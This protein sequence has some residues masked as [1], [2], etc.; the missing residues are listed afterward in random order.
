MTMIKKM[1]SVLLEFLFLFFLGIILVLV[2]TGGFSFVVGSLTVKAHGFK[3]PVL[4]LVSILIIRRFLFGSFFQG[5][6]WLR[7][8]RRI[9]ATLQS[10]SD[11]LA[12]QFVESARFRRSVTLAVFMLL[13]SVVLAIVFNPLQHGLNATYYNNI[14]GSGSPILTVR[15][16]VINLWRMLSVFPKITENYS[17]QWRGVIFIP[18]SGEYQFATRSDDGSKLALDDQLVVDN[19]GFH[20]SQE[21]TGCMHLEPGFHALKIFYWQGQGAADFRAYWT[22]PG[23]RRAEL[24]NA[25]LFPEEPA[26][27]A[28]FVG[29]WLET[30]VTVAGWLCVVGLGSGVLIGFSSHRMLVPFFRTSSVGRAY[31]TCRAWIFKAQVPKQAFPARPEKSVGVVLLAFAGYA[32]LSLAWTYPLIMNFS[33]KMV[34]IGGDRYIGLWNMWWMKKALL[35]LHVNPMYTDYLFYPQGINLAFHDYSIFN[36]LVSVPLQAFFSLPEIYNLLFL[37]TY[38]LGGLGCF[39]LVS[40]LTGDRYAAFLSGLVFAFWGGRAYYSDHLSFATIQWFPYCALYLIKTLRERSYRNP[41]RAA[42]FLAMNGLSCGYY[43]IYMALFTALFLLYSAW[44]ERKT[45]FTAACLT[46]FGLAGVL[47]GLLIFPSVYPM[48]KDVVSGESYMI[49]ALLPL[50]SASPNTL[51]LPSIN[52][53]LIGTYMRYLYLKAGLP[54]QWGLTGSAFI[55]YTVLGLCLY[56]GFKLRHLKQRFW[57]IAAVS[58]LLLAMGPHLLLFSK[59]YPSIPLPYVL[60]RYIPVLKIVRVPV[61]FMVMAMFCGSVLVGYACWDIFRRMRVKKIVFFLLAVAILFEFFRFLGIAP[62]ETTPAFYKQ[63]G[64][65]KEEYAILELTKLMNWEHSAARS[66]LFQTTHG[67]KLFHGHVSRVSL[68]TYHQAYALYTVFNDLL[69]CPP[70]K[71]VSAAGQNL[72]WGGDKKAITAMLSFYNVRYVALYYDY[73]YGNYEENRN[74]LQRLFGKPVSEEHGICLFKV[75][76]TPL[77]ENLVFP[78]F[79]IS[80]LEFRADGSILRKTARSADFKLLNVAQAQKVQIRFQG[81]SSFLPKEE[82]VQI[83]VNETLA[84]T[85]TIGD[86]TDVTIPPVAIG[87]GENTIK[88]RMLDTNSENWKHGM[89]LRN[90]E[91][92]VF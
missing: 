92:K 88:F 11:K 61:R 1:I 87:P 91:V 2:F 39:L 29:R 63:L 45:F 41:I 14:Q 46:R 10:G 62:L 66:S 23:K 3:N 58:F 77:S 56:T 43:A 89:T 72:F 27:P 79:G 65:D 48:F 69:T 67:K 73:W 25:L 9:G 86:W 36:A 44:A 68:E 5:F 22:Q 26:K 83:V 74:R 82:R 37:A 12:R 42:L 51:F 38:I 8:L 70:E 18:V 21:R 80:P 49:S 47:F 28:F 24:S 60:L 55:G 50:E 19:G 81:Q 20:G 35:E 84:T 64:Q 71:L 76:Q 52:H 17:I 7:F 53:S 4:V 33:S 75:D 15:D 54:M 90:L 32:L 6:V 59:A 85:A 34:G 16:R 78:G 40:Y 13:V 31:L 57:I 30:L